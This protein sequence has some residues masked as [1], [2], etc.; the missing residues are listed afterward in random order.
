MK[1]LRLKLLVSLILF[2][3]ILVSVV[4][5]T[6]RELLRKD[7]KVQQQKN[8]SLIE[9]HIISDMRTIDNAHFYFDSVI[10]ESMEKE[11]HEMV[12][13][14]EK[15]P[16]ILDWDLQTLKEKHGYEIYIL[17]ETNTV[18]QTTFNADIGLDF[19]AC[20]SSF[21]TILDDRRLSGTYSSDAINISTTTGELW[22]YS[23]LGTPDKKYLFELGV[24][25]NSVPL[26]EKFNF[27]NT[28]KKIIEKY[29]DL[30]DIRILNNGG[31][32]LDANP[33][34]DYSI[35]G[36]TKEF[37]DAYH[38]AL[39][40]M[41]PVQFEKKLQGGYIET[42]R[43]LPYEA[44]QSRDTSTK[45]IIYM[46]YGNESELTLLKRNIQQFWLNLAVAIV[47]SIILLIIIIRLLT[48]TISLATYDSLTGANN[49]ATYLSL[50]E[51]LLRRKK[52]ARVGLLVI[53]LDN[54]KSVNDQFG[55][56]VGD[57]VLVE[58]V[59]LLKDCVKKEGFVARFGGD[60]FAI[61]LYDASF[62]K[63]EQTA[64]T[65]LQS[66]R[67]KKEDVSNNKWNPLSISIGG[68]LQ[69]ND[70]ETE[71]SLFM[72]AD[73]ALYHSKNLGKDCYSI[74]KLEKGILS[75]KE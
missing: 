73:K 15:N 2:T 11:L 32:F 44:E 3:V 25:A 26:F 39:K 29:D 18:I 45:R 8:W 10:S 20:C 51:D 42:Y 30:K 60:E 65:I 52:K 68:A 17:D 6:N 23:Y 46:K 1:N 58:L 74:S 14:Y 47:T 61:V 27:F 21:S 62:E 33:G 64:Q 28:A 41:T 9:N 75:F 54:F 56:T 43:F 5:L 53:D 66:V 57:I 22:K 16:N 31:N 35:N 40:T 50:T 36:Q 48:N 63:L 49:R 38:Q 24:N 71:D 69:E 72:R 59:K 55:H 12:S 4:A 37:Q 34:E 70:D 13:L 19:S 7:I 67:S